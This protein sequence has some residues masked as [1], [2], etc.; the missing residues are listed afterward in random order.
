VVD[1]GVVCL[2]AEGVDVDPRDWRWWQVVVGVHTGGVDEGSQAIVVGE[3]DG[4]APLAKVL[5]EASC[6]GL[7]KMSVRPL[8]PKCWRRHV[9]VVR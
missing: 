4:E 5:V 7:L 2:G 6:R 8:L 9:V 1:G 3:A